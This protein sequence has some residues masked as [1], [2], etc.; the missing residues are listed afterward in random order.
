MLSDLRRAGV[1]TLAMEVSSH[2]LTLER[3]AGLAF[4][5]AVFTNLSRD[6]LDFHGTMENYRAVKVSLFSGLPP[7]AVAVVNGDDAVGREIMACS[8]TSVLDYG[9]TAKASLQ[10]VEIA[11]SLRGTT[12]KID[13]GGQTITIHTPLRGGF[14]VYNTLAAL[15]GCLVVGQPLARLAAAAEAL[16]GIPGRM[17]RVPLS[18]RR[19]GVVD[20]AHTPDSLEKALQTLRALSPKRIIT[21]FGCGGNRDKGKRPLMGAVAARH[22]DLCVV[23]SDNPRREDPMEIIDEILTGMPCRGVVVEPDRRTAIR[24]AYALSR[25]GDVILV[26]GKG[27]E[28]YQIVGDERLPFSDTEELRCLQ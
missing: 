14:N 20:Y 17:E 10:A 13:Y 4:D 22:S 2:A 19:I 25:P 5:V 12:L 24:Q 28:T 21:V 6:H 7:S 9:I 3:V 27:H 11:Y 1:N 15:G 26:A 23:T 16:H 8:Q 18:A